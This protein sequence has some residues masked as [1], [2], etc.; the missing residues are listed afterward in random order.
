MRSTINITITIFGKS[1]K[2]K[3]IPRNGAKIGDFLYVSGILGLSK[4][5]LD[6]YSLNLK[7]LQEAKRKYLL[8]TITLM[9][10]KDKI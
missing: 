1:P 3:S 2:G 8:I 6:N 4:I 10:L 7:E 9:M 5:G